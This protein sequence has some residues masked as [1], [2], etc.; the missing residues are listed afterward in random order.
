MHYQ[1]SV[2]K[3]GSGACMRVGDCYAARNVAVKGGENGERKV[4]FDGLSGGWADIGF[5]LLGQLI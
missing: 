1:L 3:L 2:M 4:S 5:I